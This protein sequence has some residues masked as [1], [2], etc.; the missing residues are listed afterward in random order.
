MSAANSTSSV[1]P[2]LIAFELNGKQ[3]VGQAGQTILDIALAEGIDI[4]RLCFK[5]T[6]RPDGNCRACV[7]E[8]AG[9]R[10]L[11][12]SC[13]RNISPGMQVNTLSER[14]QTSQKMVVELLLS[15]MPDD[16]F[17]WHDG[18]QTLPHGELSMWAQ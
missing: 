7:V 12:P 6:Y 9:E 2:A 18:Q 16:G 17:K 13:C 4:P 5:E 10:V 15:D 14:A 3:V 1:V 11:A 8:V